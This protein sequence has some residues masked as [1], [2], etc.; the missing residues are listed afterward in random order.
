MTAVRINAPAKIN[1]TL[2]VLG[3]RSDGYH[4]IRSIMQ[5]VDLC[6]ELTLSI[7]DDLT[8]ELS[9]ET[10]ALA[11]EA[12]EAN[13]AFRAAQL[14]QKRTRCSAGAS[15][16][17]TKGIPIAAGL[18]GGS[19]DA[20]ATLRGLRRL[21]ALNISDGELAR[22]GAELGSDVP[23]FIRGGTALVSG[24]GEIIEPLPDVAKR[25]LV[26]AWP[27]S[28]MLDKT[29]RMYAAM[30]PEHSTD[31]S[32]TERLAERIRP[33]QPLRDEDLY[34]VFEALLL[35][36]DVE[37][38]EAFEQLRSMG[39]GRP[40]LCGSGPAVFFLEGGVAQAQASSSFP[41]V[42]Y[43]AS[44]ARTLAAAE[45]VAVEELA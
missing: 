7:A 20:A 25:E 14:L 35:Q 33:G 1:W 42:Y 6:D 43:A 4:E 37:A 10:G 13:L 27:R 16:A 23:F 38:G 22:I 11:D 45:A 34:N 15:I 18:G 8:L 5:T 32:R 9:G 28:H 41:N 17:L 44:S 24:R 40:H 39:V 21:W 12:V 2:E 3:K 29:A 19:T 30:R 31:G 36:I 26:V